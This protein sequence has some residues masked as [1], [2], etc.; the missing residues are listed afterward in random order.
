MTLKSDAKFNEKLT[1]GF[2]N[3]M[4]NSVNFHPTNQKSE[5]FFSMGSFYPKY[6]SFELK[7]YRGVIFYDTES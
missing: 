6:I 4:M 2:K 1:W 5:N 3:G 7:K